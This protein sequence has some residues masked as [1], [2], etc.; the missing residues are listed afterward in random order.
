MKELGGGIKILLVFVLSVQV[1]C[2]MM[3]ALLLVTGT[4][5]P[6]EKGA[7]IGLLALIS[8]ISV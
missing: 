4:E 8:I 6:K 3:Q 1:R 5:R 2:P 7:V